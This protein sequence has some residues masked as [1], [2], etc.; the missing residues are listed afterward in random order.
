MAFLHHGVARM[1]FQRL[2]VINVTGGK[3]FRLSGFKT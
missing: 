2:K 3:R 1:T